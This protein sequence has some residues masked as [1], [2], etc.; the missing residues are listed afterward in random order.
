LTGIEL[1][2]GFF[3]FHSRT[4]SCCSM[5]FAGIGCLFLFLASA[6]ATGIFI[7]YKDEFN[8]N[9][10]SFGVTASLGSKAFILTWVAAAASLVSA[11]WWMFSICCGST[12][13]GRSHEEEKE[14]FIG[15][16]PHHGY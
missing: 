6:L 12:R 3:A 7:V 2:I 9:L 11:V 4:A 10:S 5:L 15:Y 8:K 16:V 14:P 13:Y 1:F